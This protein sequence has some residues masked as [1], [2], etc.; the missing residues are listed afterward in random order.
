MNVLVFD[1]ETVPDVAAGR[2]LF[3]LNGLDDF[4]VA[5]VMFSQRSQETHGSSEFLRH[6]LHRVV[7]VSVALRSADKFSVWSLGGP[8]SDECELIQR[9]FEG[10]ERYVPVLVSW[11]GRGFDL[12]VLRYRALRHGVTAA[13]YWQNGEGDASFRWNNYL[14]RFH[15]RHTDLMDVLSGYEWRA[16]APLHEVAMLLGLPGKLGLSGADVWERYRAG[17]ISSI[18]DYCETDVLN[19]YLIYLRYKLM[20]GSLTEEAHEVELNRVKEFLQ[21]QR[22]PHFARFLS[23]WRHG[24]N[25]SVP[26]LQN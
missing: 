9:F 25:F 13:R 14:N 21:Q 18:R 16:C 3:D 8:E 5:N 22:E 7:A 23:A 20:R 15:E 19:T 6:H 26:S 10:I 24:D 17:D 4:E 11:N 1:I 12:P 2:R